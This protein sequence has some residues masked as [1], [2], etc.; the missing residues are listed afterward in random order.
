M[1]EF[2]TIPNLPVPKGANLRVPHDRLTRP[3]VVIVGFTEHRKL[4]FDGTFPREEFEV[5]C[6][7]E[8]HRY[9]EVRDVDRWFE[10]HNR[11]DLEGDPDHLKALAGMDIPVYMQRHWDDIPPSVPFPREFVEKVVGTY[12][13]SSPAWMLGMA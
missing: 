5:W 1:T 4:A 3:G 12:E 11:N 9:E 10:I 13:T 2:P 7:N 8:L 6:L